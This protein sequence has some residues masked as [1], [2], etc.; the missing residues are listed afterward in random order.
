M[1]GDAKAGLEWVTEIVIIE[2]LLE[3]KISVGTGPKTPRKRKADVDMDVLLGLS[4]GKKGELDMLPGGSAGEAD[5]TYDVAAAVA[6]DAA[7]NTP[8]KSSAVAV[9]TAPVAGPSNQPLFV[10]VEAEVA[11]ETEGEGEEEQEEQEEQ[12][13]VVVGKG[14]AKAKPSRHGRK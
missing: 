13:Q 8:T 1:S 7:P 3:E 6:M 4:S 9:V 5:S 10:N 2:G 14:K 11:Y 12:E